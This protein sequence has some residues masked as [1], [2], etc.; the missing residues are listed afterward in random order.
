[1]ED[2]ERGRE[3]QDEKAR[4]EGVQIGRGCRI[5]NRGKVENKEKMKT[6]REE[7]KREN[8]REEEGRMIIMD[9]ATTSFLLLLLLLLPR[10]QLTSPPV[11]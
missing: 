5:K 3:K 11:T 9:T 1:M 2:R 10:D 7:R 8:E 6:E 4:R